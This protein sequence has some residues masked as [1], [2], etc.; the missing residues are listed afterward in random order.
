FEGSL[1]LPDPTLIANGRGSETND[2]PVDLCPASLGVFELFQHQR[3]CAFAHYGT[4]AVAVEG[5]TESRWLAVA[6]SHLLLRNHMNGA[7]RM[8]LRPGGARQNGVGM[9]ANDRAIRLGD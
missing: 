2:F 6:D 5:A 3:R 1:V 9:T 8:H 4:R 7:G